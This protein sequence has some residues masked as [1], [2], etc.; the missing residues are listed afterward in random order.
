MD[1]GLA[2]GSPVTRPRHPAAAVRT[3]T[4]ATAVPRDG[5]MHPGRKVI[6]RVIVNRD[7]EKRLRVENVPPWR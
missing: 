6:S 7:Y 2:T 4:S 3:I 5:S 1:A